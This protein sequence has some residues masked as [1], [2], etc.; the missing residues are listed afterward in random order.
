MYFLCNAGTIAQGALS[1]PL[2]PMLQQ[3]VLVLRA[4]T[5]RKGPSSRWS[6]SPAPTR[7]RH[8][9]LGASAVRQAGTAFPALFTCVQQVGCQQQQQQQQVACLLFC[10][11]FFLKL[12]NY[13]DF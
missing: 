1:L 10:V 13:K 11:P 6:V 5:V 9:P 12:L 2:P 8:T 4:P 7:Q 3:G